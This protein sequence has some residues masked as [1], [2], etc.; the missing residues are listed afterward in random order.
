V[1]GVQTCALPIYE[2]A[3][4][5]NPN[6]ALAYHNKGVALYNLRH[7]QEALAAYEQAIHLDPSLALAYKGKGLVLEDLGKKQEAQQ[8]YERAKQL[9]YSS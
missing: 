4:H 3:I 1:T 7:Y 6:Y 9:G 8:A 5:L 2:Q